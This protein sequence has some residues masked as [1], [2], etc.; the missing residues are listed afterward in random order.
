MPEAPRAKAAESRRR[1]QRRSWRP[2]KRWK[3]GY[4]MLRKAGRDAPQVRVWE[5]E[6]ARVCVTVC[7][8]WRRPQHNA[9]AGNAVATGMKGGRGRD[10]MKEHTAVRGK[11]RREGR[12]EKTRREGER[13]ET[14]W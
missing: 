7:V 12:K 11:E 4:E 9:R 13:K 10:G 2:A 1:L 8:L 5:G 3:C 14:G 6:C